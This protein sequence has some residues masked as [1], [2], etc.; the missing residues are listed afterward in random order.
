MILD[1]IIE[2]KRIRVNERKAQAS[3]E[4]IKHKA[5]AAAGNSPSQFANALKPTSGM[6]VI[7]EVKKASPSKG[8]ISPEFD[9]LA[10]A[11]QYQ[12]GGAA[13]ISVLTEEDF[14][15]GSD[16]YFT[17]IKAH[18]YLPILRKDFIIDEYQVYESKVLGADAILLICRILSYDELERFFGI[19]QK[20]SLDCLFETHSAEEVRRALR[21]GAK[22]IGVNNR[23]L[24]T[25]N[26]DLKTSEDLTSLIP[27]SVIKVSESGIVSAEDTARLKKSGFGAVLVGETLMKSQNIDAMLHNLTLNPPKIKICGL[28]SMAD[29][30]IVNEC[31][32]D[33]AGFVFA[34]SKRQVSISEAKCMIERLNNSITPVGVFVNAEIEEITQAV[35]AGIRVVQLHGDEKY[36][37]RLKSLPIQIW[38][39]IKVHD[40][41]VNILE[42]VDAVLLDSYNE[43]MQGGTGQTFNWDIVQRLKINKP[44]ILAGGLNERNVS[45]AITITNPY[46]VDV[47]SGVET[48][49]KKDKDKVK[50]FCGKVRSNLSE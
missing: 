31:L 14:F 4:E 24:D 46:C 20:L 36:I 30:E 16:K 34:P 44:I 29:I 40:E 45:R 25:F 26:V 21:V 49:G 38:K 28:R 39:T 2:K 47:S 12:Q 48:D 11:K 27:D 13:A 17:D 42:N 5:L 41:N 3:L 8:L 19:A 37:D 35:K 33:F 43:K 6:A 7:A 32:P 18:I 1:K 9:Y 23:D 10:I 50:M 22:I 15:L